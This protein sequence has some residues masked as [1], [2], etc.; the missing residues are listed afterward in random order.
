MRTPRNELGALLAALLLPIEHGEGEAR[1]EKGE[2]G[3]SQSTGERIEHPI[4]KP[5]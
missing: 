1:E 2:R 5:T 3:I 4:C